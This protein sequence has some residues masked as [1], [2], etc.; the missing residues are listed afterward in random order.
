MRFLGL[1]CFLFVAGFSSLVAET[2]VSNQ[3]EFRL[4]GRGDLSG[5]TV[6]FKSLD[7]VLTSDAKGNLSSPL[8]SGQ[9]VFSLAPGEY[10]VEVIAGGQTAGDRLKIPP[11]EHSLITIEIGPLQKTLTRNVTRQLSA[12]QVR[13]T[14][15][16]DRSLE[17]LTA[18]EARSIPGA[19]GDIL[20]GILNFP[21]VAPQ[22]IQSQDL[23]VRGGGKND[24]VFYYEGVPIGNP[25][26]DLG[27]YSVF[28]ST[29][30]ESVAFFPGAFPARI[31][32]SQGA[33][34]EI[35]AKSSYDK[36]RPVFDFDANLAQAGG[37]LSIPLGKYFQFSVN[38]RRTF[39][40]TYLALVNSLKIDDP[41][42][43][44]VQKA[45]S[46]LTPYFYDYTG[47]LDFH[48]DDKNFFTLFALG[49]DDRLTIHS[50]NAGTVFE[51]TNYNLD[52]VW[53]SEALL[54]H[55]RGK[56]FR[57]DVS[58]S[59]YS[60]SNDEV[61]QEVPR[62]RLSSTYY[63]LRDSAEW[64][65][66]EHVSISAGG[67]YEYQTSPVTSVELDHP[68][69][70]LD[71]FN[72]VLGGDASAYINAQKRTNTFRAERHRLG[73]Y[74][75]ANIDL[76]PFT[77]T[78]GMRMGWDHLSKQVEGDPRLSVTFRPAKHLELF[79]R[80]GRYSQLVDI[81][82]AAAGYGNPAL[83]SPYTFHFVLGGRFVLPP[84]EV[85]LETYY[86][87]MRNQA[88]DNPSYNYFFPSDA[89]NPRFISD[90]L[91]RSYGAELLARKQLSSG[92]FGW[93]AYSLSRS[94]RYNYLTPSGFYAN[95]L[96]NNGLDYKSFSRA[97]QAYDQDVTHS[98]SFA[99]SWDIVPRHL[100]LGTRVG[101][102]SGKP[103]TETLV[104]QNGAG[105]LGLASST[106]SLGARLPLRFSLDLRLDYTLKLFKKV[107]LT[108]YVDI[109]NAQYFWYPN[110][111]YYT[112]IATNLSAD[113]VGKVAPRESQTDLPIIPLLG[114]EVSF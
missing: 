32:R 25:F 53:D 27:F 90:G 79:G 89:N 96:S 106:N 4:L 37:Y 84:F 20:R 64:H 62:S 112:P 36:T 86:K 58:L 48:P 61:F 11:E 103:F 19:G 17:V 88:V 68:S 21:G 101:L 80:V 3:C 70:D 75:D 6:L 1:F 51:T 99:G 85:K 18:K 107:D 15:R 57:N 22:S 87:D 114:V 23:I 30:L 93:L 2:A 16:S 97:W 98:L 5:V 110:V 8:S 46:N 82:Q 91:G 54:Y 81:T 105:T 78:P 26:H 63:R 56:I 13:D 47:R 95:P 60:F 7:L 10:E 77:F 109:W 49:S 12:L 41:D 92:L 59:R 31:G 28:P 43:R 50:K 34:L 72:L 29:A 44:K 9:K 52:E 55:Y 14:G 24:I 74:A 38:G 42:F 111:L 69:Q 40:E 73:A 33:A 94:E 45:F 76:G 35:F 100:K 39:Y 108:F 83:T 102:S 113:Q 66:G 71:F 67:E 104:S 65:V